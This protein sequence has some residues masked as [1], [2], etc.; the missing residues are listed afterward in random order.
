MKNAADPT[1]TFTVQEYTEVTPAWALFGSEE[2]GFDPID[3]RH[4]KAQKHPMYTQ[5]DSRGVPTHDHVKELIG[6]KERERLLAIM[7]QKL[8]EVGAGTT[9]TE[10]K[11]G[12]KLIGDASLMFRG[13][14]VTH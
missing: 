11:G 9:V 1:F 3:L 14:I 12:E 8:K 4:R 2:E 10:L 6:A 7:D 5:F 13:M